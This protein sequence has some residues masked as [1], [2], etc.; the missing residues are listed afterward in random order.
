MWLSLENLTKTALA[1]LRERASDASDCP[2]T[3][4]TGHPGTLPFGRSAE[5][6][7]EE[8]RESYSNR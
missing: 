8:N 4:S 7:R 1:M 2:V 6:R 3:G 5:G